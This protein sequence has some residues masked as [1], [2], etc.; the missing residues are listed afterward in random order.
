[1]YRDGQWA[2]NE[3]VSEILM[4]GVIIDLNYYH[5]KLEFLRF[6]KGEE[7]YGDYY[8]SFYFDFYLLVEFLLRNE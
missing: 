6:R 8:Y 4:M 2:I 1:M 7:S 5:F 3:V